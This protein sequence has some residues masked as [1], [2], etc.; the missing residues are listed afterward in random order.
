MPVRY[1]DV[2]KPSAMKLEAQAIARAQLRRI[3]GIAFAYL[4]LHLA[5]AA[6][7]LYNEY[8]L[9]EWTVRY[10]PLAKDDH[11]HFIWWWFVYLPIFIFCYGLFEL[12]P[13]A[14]LYRD[15]KALEEATIIIMP[16]RVNTLFMLHTLGVLLFIL[17]TGLTLTSRD[18]S[19]SQLLLLICWGT[20]ARIG[21]FI[22]SKI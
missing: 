12:W 1:I 14:K 20:Y 11:F 4:V 3:F 9:G 17:A 10:L 15:R 16:R 6:L 2:T 8:V 21:G 5:F 18:A 19:G 22:G 13:Y 7:T